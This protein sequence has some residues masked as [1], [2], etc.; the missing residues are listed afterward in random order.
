MTKATRESLFTLAY[1][2][3]GV[4]AVLIVG[5]L[6]FRHRFFHYPKPLLPFIIVGLTGSL[7]YAAVQMRGAGLVL[8]LIALLYFT[9]VALAPPIRSRS[10]A[11]AA[12]FA[13]PVGFALMA[14][15]YVQKS[16][17][18]LKFGRFVAMG[19]IVGAGYGLMM[20]LFLIQSRVGLQMGTVFKQAV[21]GFE[22]GAAM[23]LGF[24]LVDRIGPRPRHQVGYDVPLS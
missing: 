9:Q 3:I 1:V 2:V 21:I 13:L 16:L 12:V 6:T 18:R 17:A 5:Y 7:I 20:A 24:E 14:G 22:L 15:A 23:G 19:L 8:L 11:T 4:V 10:L